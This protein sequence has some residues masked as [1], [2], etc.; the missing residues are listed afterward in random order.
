MDQKRSV[1][2]EKPWDEVYGYSRA[3]RRGNIIFVSGT[4]APSKSEGDTK[5]PVYTQTVSIIRI[6][7][8]A[9]A[10]LGATLDDVVRTRTF[11]KDISKWEEIAK[12][13]AEF[14]GAT[15]PTAT[16]VEVSNLIEPDA[17]LEMEVDAI[18]EEPARERTLTP[19]YRK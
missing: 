17:L 7:E 16:L 15:K 13:H 1:H 2:G 18:L 5:S 6:I 8:G 19:S 4:T 11:A 12:A 14:F 10:E 9:L 3:V